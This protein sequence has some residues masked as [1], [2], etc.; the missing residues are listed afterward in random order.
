MFEFIGLASLVASCVF[1]VTYRL[2]QHWR[3]ALAVATFALVGVFPLVFE[4]LN[5]EV[6]SCGVHSQHCEVQRIPGLSSEQ[7]HER[8][9]VAGY[10]PEG[11]VCLVKTD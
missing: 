1:L 3:V 9:D 2:H 5:Q 7:C 4:V 6:V 8:S 10:L 11:G